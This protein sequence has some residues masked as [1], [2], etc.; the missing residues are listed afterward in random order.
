[1]V[2]ACRP[3]RQHCLSHACAVVVIAALKTRDKRLACVAAADYSEFS[4][5]PHNAARNAANFASAPSRWADCAKAAWIAA[6]SPQDSCVGTAGRARA[7]VRRDRRC[8]CAAGGLMWADAPVSVRR[9]RAPCPAGPPW[10]RH[11]SAPR[12]RATAGNGPARGRYRSGARPQRLHRSARALRRPAGSPAGRRR[13]CTGRWPARAFRPRRGRGPARRCVSSSGSASSV[14][15]TALSATARPLELVGNR[16]IV[17]AIEGLH[18]GQR[19][20]A[21]SH[22]FF[23]APLSGDCRCECA[24]MS[25]SS[26]RFGGRVA[27]QAV[28]QRPQHRLGFGRPILS[29]QRVR[30]VT[31]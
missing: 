21:Q 17:R 7:T 30:Q 22:G 25:A 29:A 14:R 6:A 19:F 20:A 8:G 2:S 24:S 13:G 12:S 11:R 18:H 23:V 4:P 31:A 16:R 15:P 10:Y 28:Q 5:L 9:A 26:T 3:R 27:A 1:M